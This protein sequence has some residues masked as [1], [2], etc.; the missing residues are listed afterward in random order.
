VNVKNVLTVAP[1]NASE[2]MGLNFT[3]NGFTA[4][5]GKDG[6]ENP[7]AGHGRQRQLGE[8]PLTGEIDGQ[9]S[10]DDFMQRRMSLWRSV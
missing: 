1:S 5:H 9:F 10:P 8:E 3:G 7:A 2:N 6:S 4:E